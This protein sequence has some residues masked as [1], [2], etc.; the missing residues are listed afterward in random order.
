MTETI[1]LRVN[2]YYWGTKILDGNQYRFDLWWNI[3]TSRWY[4][5]ITGLNNTVSIKGIALVPG[6]ELIGKY[7]YEDILGQLHVIDNQGANED[8]NFDDIGSRWTL[9]YTPLPVRV[10]QTI[11]ASEIVERLIY[12]NTSYSGSLS[13]NGALAAYFT[14]NFVQGMDVSWQVL[15]AL[16]SNAG[17]GGSFYNQSSDWGI[18]DTSAPTIGSNDPIVIA[19]NELATF[20]EASVQLS[21]VG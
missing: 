3:E 1:N 15:Y 13:D 17:L 11:Y 6:Q 7:G 16:A 10:E 2:P 4:A 5:S 21:G 14:A 18:S 9:E 8:P 19:A 20:T 12:V